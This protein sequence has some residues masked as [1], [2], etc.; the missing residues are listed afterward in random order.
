MR[1]R[2]QR[3]M[4]QPQ[5]YIACQEG[6]AAIVTLLLAHDGI[7]VNQARTDSGLTALHGAVFG[8]VLLAV[9]YLVVYGASLAAAAFIDGSTPAQVAAF[10]NKPELAE[11]LNA[12]SGWSQLRVAAGCRLYKDAAFLLRRGKIDPD[13]PATTSTKDIM[14]VVA[15][16]TANPEQSSGSGSEAAVY[17]ASCTGRGRGRRRGPKTP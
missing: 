16:A 9:Q 15:T 13:D 3:I 6:H 1:T 11:W 4:V 5:L 14:A 10:V 8:G 17:R 12:V 7:D 2:Q